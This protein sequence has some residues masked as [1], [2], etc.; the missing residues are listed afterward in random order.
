MVTSQPFFAKKEA[1]DKP[2]KP[3]PITNALLE[4]VLIY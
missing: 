1:A 3:A 2:A 4:C